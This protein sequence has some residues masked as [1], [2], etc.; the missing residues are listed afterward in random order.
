MIGHELLISLSF[1]RDLVMMK[2]VARR[3]QACGL[4]F[5]KAS[6]L[7][8]SYYSLHAVHSRPTLNDVI[9]QLFWHGSVHEPKECYLENKSALY[10][11]I[12]ENPPGEK[13]MITRVSTDA[14]FVSIEAQQDSTPSQVHLVTLWKKK[15]N[16]LSICIIM[17]ICV[18]LLLNFCVIRVVELF[19]V[20]F[21]SFA[22][23]VTSVF[24]GILY[25]AWCSILCL[26]EAIWNAFSIIV[27]YL[28]KAHIY[29]SLWILMIDWEA[30]ND[31][32]LHVMLFKG[33][34]NHA[35][36]QKNG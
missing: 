36:F 19:H 4:L 22:I 9:K 27:T 33:I 16:F 5:Y 17:V 13:V 12:C 11:K 2:F 30:R 35:E 8:F 23:I 20:L 1:C 15:V 10:E 25:Q 31:L 34:E 24:V 29:M 21:V 28:R 26:D 6:F 32:K 18:L 7:Q 14:I 3:L